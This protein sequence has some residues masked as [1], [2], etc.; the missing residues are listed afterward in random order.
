MTIPFVSIIRSGSYIYPFQGF[1]YFWKHPKIWPLYLT[2]LIPQLMITMTIYS[3]MFIF[4]YPAQLVV[5]ML[6]TGPLGMVFAWYSIYWTSS[7]I[8]CFLVTVTLLP[9]IQKVAYDAVLSRERYDIYVRISKARRIENRQLPIV[10]RMTKYLGRLPGLSIFPFTVPKLL[11]LFFVGMIPV[12]G[13][14]VVIFFRASSKGLRAHDRYY[15]MR[16]LST[17]E[18]NASYKQNKPV[19]MAFGLAAL[20]LEMI[21]V[22]NI[23]FMFT[24]N[25]GA[26]L[27]AVDLDKNE[28]EYAERNYLVP[29]QKK[30]ATKLAQ[31]VPNEPNTVVSTGNSSMHTGTR[32]REPEASVV[33]T[34]RLDAGL[35]VHGGQDDESDF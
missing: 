15:K 24:N 23:F 7:T 5:Y 16:G 21:P 31:L 10:R 32:L 9:Y 19:Y 4:I 20:L 8:A 3:L 30:Q 26:A 18:I 22:F 12:I 27:W 34:H 17:Q 11:V 1:L 35:E 14:F 28:E 13:P 25:I 2:V 33:N 6:L 29:Q